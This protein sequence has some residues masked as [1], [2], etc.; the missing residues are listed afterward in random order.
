MTDK[1]F[2]KLMDKLDECGM[3]EDTMVMVTTD[4]GYFLGE[5][6]YMGKNYMHLYNELAHLPFIVH[7]PGDARAG[8]HAHQV[9]QAIDIMPTV[10]EAHGCAIPEE[11]RGVSLMPLMTDP[12]APTR[13]YALYGVHAMTVNVTDGEFTY[14]RAPVP[15][16]QPCYE[17]AALPHTIRKKMGSDCPE[18]IECGRYFARTRYPLFKIPCK[19]PAQIEGATPLA[20]VSQTMLFDLA[21]D[22]GQRNNL[23]GKDDPREARMIDLLLRGLEEHEAPAEQK[24]RLGLV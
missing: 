23:A 11:V 1:W 22:Y 2:G 17:Y 12:D 24:I 21:E 9:T 19:R 6:D 18:E 13:E 7:F 5:R 14:F 16:N 20:E 3:L 10:L 4:H 15:G 8:E